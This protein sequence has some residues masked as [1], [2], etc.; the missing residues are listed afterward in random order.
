MDVVRERVVE[1]WEGDAILGSDR[2][3]DD[4]LV[5]IVELVPVLIL[6]WIFLDQRFELWTTGDSLIERLRSEER[7]QIEEIK[8]VVVDQIS[9]KLITKSVERRLL[10]KM[11]EPTFVARSVYA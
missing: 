7:L 3:S 1:I 4:D 11:Q 9:E 5:D 8:V 2:L 6:K 10:I